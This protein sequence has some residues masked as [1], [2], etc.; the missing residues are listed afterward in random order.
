[1]FGTSD[2]TS[3]GVVYICQ[4]GA[5]ENGEGILNRLQ[6]HKSNPEKDYW[7]EAIDFTTSDNSF[8]STEI[9]YLE[10]RLCNIAI[11]AKRYE[12]KNVDDSTPGSIIEEKE[13]EMQY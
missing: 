9:N 10:N 8:G 7:T 2:E 6:E 5:R 3:N 1:M 11:E 12:V 4:A 13:S